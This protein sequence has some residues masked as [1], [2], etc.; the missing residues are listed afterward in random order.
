MKKNVRSDTQ[1]AIGLRSLLD[2]ECKSPKTQVSN[3]CNLQSLLG[4]QGNHIYN[5]RDVF[6]PEPAGILIIRL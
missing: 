4:W 5:C 3:W 6:A 1:E 2:S